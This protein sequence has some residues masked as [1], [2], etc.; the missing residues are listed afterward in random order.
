MF[1][2]SQSA[3][4]RCAMLLYRKEMSNWEEALK[5]IKKT[6][7]KQQKM[8]KV[9]KQPPTQSEQKPVEADHQDNALLDTSDAQ[10]V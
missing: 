10:T 4:A 7:A 9:K 5:T 2:C 3:D 1:H 8:P 6:N